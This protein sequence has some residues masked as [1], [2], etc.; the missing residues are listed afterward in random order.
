MARTSQK[1]KRGGKNIRKNYTKKCLNDPDYHD[2]VATPLEP[3]IPEYEVK[4]ALGIITT[5]K[6]FGVDRISAELFKIEKMMLLKPCTQY[7]SKF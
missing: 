4:R 2:G 6:T 1:Q 5:H 3:D 7:V